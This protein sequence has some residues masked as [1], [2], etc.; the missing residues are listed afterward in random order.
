MI[1]IGTSRTA[2]LHLLGPGVLRIHAV[3][4]YG[5]LIDLATGDRTLVNGMPVERHRLATG[6]RITI[7]EYQIDVT[8]G[9]TYDALELKLLDAIEAHDTDALDVYA[10]WLEERGDTRR[11]EILRIEQRLASPISF[12]DRRALEETQRDLM[13]DLARDLDEDWLRRVAPY[14]T[15]RLLAPPRPRTSKSDWDLPHQLHYLY[16]LQPRT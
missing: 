9:T 7:G 8:V 3:V 15:R 6:D 2:R 16:D 12:L 5:E 11:A 14:A 13:L 1:T 10:D 4:D